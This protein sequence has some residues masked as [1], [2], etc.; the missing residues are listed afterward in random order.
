MIR[1]EHPE[2]LLLLIGLAIV[3]G[4]YG[5]Y[6]YWR[7]RALLQF[8]EHHLLR[9][10]L[11]DYSRMK[12][13]IRFIITVVTFVLIVFGLINVQMGSS[14]KKVHHSGIDIALLMD[15]SNSML[16]TDAIPD[17][18]DVARKTAEQLT[19]LFPDSRIAII[20]FAG[21][22]STLLPL[23]PDHAAAEMVLENLT[24][25]SAGLQG[26]DFASGLKEAIRALP[27]N[28]NRYR[29]IVIFSDGED[30]EHDVNVALRQAFQKDIVICTAAVGTEAGS[31]IPLGN[32]AV[33]K[34]TK[35][36]IVVTKMKPSLLKQVAEKT[37][38]IAVLLQSNSGLNE[39]A[40]RLNAIQ[41]NEM[42]E[43][44]FVQYESRFQYF[45]LPALLLL[46]LETFFSNRKKI[47]RAEKKFA[48]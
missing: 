22:S 21:S 39:I 38:G 48:V 14:Y 46:I 26:T 35:G 2:Y 36:N 37:N 40:T 34:D 7:K 12:S 33:K 20:S 3:G 27:A 31:E 42:D 16:A 32:G 19:D 45:L 47:K 10:I 18:L 8:G 11:I 23:T 4:V 24:T 13:V 1:I 5:W 6:S 44:I 43:K 41:K 17:R 9:N 15:V 28:Q 30:H 25:T 29:A